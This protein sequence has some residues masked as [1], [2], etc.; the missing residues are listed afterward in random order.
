[1]KTACDELNGIIASEDLK[2]SENAEKAEVAIKTFR[3]ESDANKLSSI[4]LGI[5][6]KDVNKPLD[7]NDNN[8][9]YSDKTDFDVSSFPYK[10]YENGPDY[11]A[12][13][14]KCVHL[15]GDEVIANYL[16]ASLLANAL[17]FVEEDCEVANSDSE[18]SRLNLPVFVLF[19]AGSVFKIVFALV[20]PAF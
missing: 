9:A 15:R 17:C 1:M 10:W 13:E 4:A 12:S 20:G 3:G 5:T 11:D 14:Y 2:D 19:M 16:C 6:A 18:R 8:F 7:E